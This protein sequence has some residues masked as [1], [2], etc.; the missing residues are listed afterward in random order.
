MHSEQLLKARAYEAEKEKAI[1][2]DMR[3]AFHLSARVGWMNDPNGLCRYQGKYHLFYQYNPY[4]THWGPMH[5][6]HAVSEDLLHWE[7]LPCA[8]APDMPYDNGG[9]CFSGSAI[10]LP[11]GRHLLM[12]TGVRLE[13]YEDG[14]V[15]EFQ[16]QCLAVGDGVDYEKVAHNPV[17][18][19]KD[20]PEGASRVD[21]R[22][23]KIW[24]G[25]DG[26]YRAAVASRPQ[27]G[28][29]QILLFKSEDALHW[30]Y[31]KKLAENRCRYGRMWECPD[32]FVL[33]GK[34][35][36]LVSPQDMTGKGVEY[37]PGNGNIA[38]IGNYDEATDTFTEESVQVIDDGVDYYAMQTVTAPDGRRI[39]IAWMQNWDALEHLP[40]EKWFGQTSLPREIAVKNGRLCQQPIR[41]LESLRVGTVTHTGVEVEGR[42]E[43]PG[44]CGRCAD[45]TLSLS[46]AY[47]RFTV[48]LAEEGD[49][50]TTLT[51][52]PDRQ[53][54]ILDRRSSGT[55]R[56]FVHKRRC[57]VDTCGREIR[58]RVIL[59]R[60]SVEVFAGEGEKTMSMVLHT[61]QTAAGISF[62]AEGSAV[63]DVVLHELKH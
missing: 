3:P 37:H 40:E 19:A 42:V 29:G 41:E 14:T 52:E 4:R 11:D 6:A 18:D 30:R 45:M 59:D 12:Y 39:M 35:V 7:T 2:P 27:D 55:R 60:N 54:L 24:L 46:G 36:L 61:P 50:K 31:E 15:D 57:I 33:D 5:W 28:S 53:T 51:W 63:M 38:V 26:V 1:T 21:F 23:P 62:E 32:F 44:V 56:A 9:G 49:L 10:E 20:L 58:L 48:N 25:S 17:L 34:A 16:T 8:L 47:E 22:D 43:L 13:K